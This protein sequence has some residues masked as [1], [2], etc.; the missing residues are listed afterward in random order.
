MRDTQLQPRAMTYA[1]FG[2]ALGT[3]EALR[4]RMRR[5]FGEPFD[6]FFGEPFTAEL[7][8]PTVGWTPVMEVA[9]SASEFTVTAELPGMTRKDIEIDFQDGV[10]T[11]RGEKEEKKEEKVNGRRYHVYERTYGAFERSFGVPLADPDRIKA[12]FADGVL[13]V[14]LPKLAEKELHGRKIEIADG[15]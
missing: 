13:T 11:I 1:P 6:R 12:E 7:F 10:L 2:S 3:T 9:E 15:K 4:S 8:A 5:L 14:H